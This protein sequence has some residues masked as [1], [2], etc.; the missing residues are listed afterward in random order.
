MVE[1]GFVFCW[2]IG[3]GVGCFGGWFAPS[4]M[5]IAPN[6]SSWRD[7]QFESGSRVVARDL[8]R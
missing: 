3:G 8:G 4:L 2:K 5:K 6:V 7:L 1:A